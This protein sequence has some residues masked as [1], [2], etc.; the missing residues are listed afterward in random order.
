MDNLKNSVETANQRLPC[1]ITVFYVKATQL[2]LKPGKY[3]APK[4]ANLIL[5]VV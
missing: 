2:M 4:N 3:A 5:V 1:I